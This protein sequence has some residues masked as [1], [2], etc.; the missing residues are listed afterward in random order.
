M[1][2]GTVSWWEIDVPDAGR[3]QQFYAAVCPTWTFHPMEGFEGYVMVHVNDTAIGAL[4]A[5]TDSDPSGRG[6]RLYADV[7][8]LEDT[9][10]RVK[11]GGGKVEQ[12]RM[13]IPGDQWIGTARDPFGNRIGFVTSNAAK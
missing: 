6:T 8:D 13:Q 3:A 1:A 10:S 7:N 12:E 5:S 2:E 9:L 4:Q 11:Q